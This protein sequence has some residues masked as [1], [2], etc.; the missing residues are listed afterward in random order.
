MD[1]ELK[2]EK[3]R[4]IEERTKE[5]LVKIFDAKVEALWQLGEPADRPAIP[6]AGNV[7]AVSDVERLVADEAI[8]AIAEKYGVKK[9]DLYMF[10]RAHYLIV[11]HN[12][13]ARMPLRIEYSEAFVDRIRWH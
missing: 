8:V 6:T 3:L 5:E 1:D 10:R 2:D 11:C 7:P 12:L 9:H 4:R 13:C